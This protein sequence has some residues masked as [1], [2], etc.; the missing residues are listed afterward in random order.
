[1]VDSTELYT[2]LSNTGNYN[3]PRQYATKVGYDQKEMTVDGVNFTNITITGIPD[4]V[5]PIAN[6]ALVNKNALRR[7][8]IFSDNQLSDQYLESIDRFYGKVPY[9][10]VYCNVPNDT[11]DTVPEENFYA[12][13]GPP[14]SVSQFVE[15]RYLHQRHLITNVAYDP[16]TNN[17]YKLC[18][19]ESPLMVIVMPANFIRTG[20]KT[21]YFKFDNNLIIRVYSRYMLSSSNAADDQNEI[22]VFSNYNIRL[23]STIEQLF[24]RFGMHKIVSN[25]DNQIYGY[26][27]FMTMVVG[28]VSNIVLPP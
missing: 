27:K 3:Y 24:S 12:C 7:L 28:S 15:Y 8:Y 1:M 17:I 11:L 23:K 2:N 14:S 20:L 13:D 10:I 22:T 21:G 19:P 9:P 4:G 25:R 18:L 16:N 6:E 26:D 5:S